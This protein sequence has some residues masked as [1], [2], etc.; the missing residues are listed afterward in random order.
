MEKVKTDKPKKKTRPPKFDYESDGFLSYIEELAQKGFTDKN[1]AFA[2]IQK[3]GEVLNTTYFYELK[4]EKDTKTGKPTKRGGKISEALARGREKINLFA[5]D[6]YF[7]AAIGGKK[8]KDVYRVF[9]EYKC[10]CGG[11]DR[12]CPLC[13]GTGRVFSTNKAVIQEVEREMPPNL[14]A[15]GTWLFNHDEEWRKS[16][17]EGKKLDVTTNGKDIHGN[18]Q[19]EIIDKR[20]QIENPDDTGL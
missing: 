5:R 11:S 16:V 17:I 20:E 14:Q 3:Y 1:I 7:K 13:H 6:T 12:E 2:L 18:I 4:N 9:A 8:T 10:E 19:V 15:L